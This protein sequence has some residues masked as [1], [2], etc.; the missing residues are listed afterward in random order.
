MRKIGHMK[1]KERKRE[2]EVKRMDI[3]WKKKGAGKYEVGKFFENIFLG[4]ENGSD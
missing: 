1:R 3:C 4:K 2:R